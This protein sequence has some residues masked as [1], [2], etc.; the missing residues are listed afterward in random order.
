MSPVST[1]LAPLRPDKLVTNNDKSDCHYETQADCTNCWWQTNE[2][3]DWSL[4]L[5]CVLS[6]RVLVRTKR[7][8]CASPVKLMVTWADWTRVAVHI[9]PRDL[10]RHQSPTTPPHCHHNRSSLSINT[11]KW[12]S[13]HLPISYAWNSPNSAWYATSR[14]IDAHATFPRSYREHEDANG[15]VNKSIPQLIALPTVSKVLI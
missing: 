11:A 9:A 15:F 3:L 12:A 8:I 6:C 14:Y 7:V 1:D 13:A 5:T 10:S 4:P 2:G